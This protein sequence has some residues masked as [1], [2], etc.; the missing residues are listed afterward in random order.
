MATRQYSLDHAKG[1]ISIFTFCCWTFFFFILLL[2]RLIFRVV[3]LSCYLTL[4]LHQIH[5]LCHSAGHQIDMVCFNSVIYRVVVDIILFTVVVSL[6][7]YFFR[8]ISMRVVVWLDNESR[9]RSMQ[10]HFRYCC[11]SNC[12]SEYFF[13]D[14]THNTSKGKVI[15]IAAFVA[16][17]LSFIHSIFFF[18]VNWKIWKKTLHK[19]LIFNIIIFIHA[20]RI[21]HLWTNKNV[22]P[23]KCTME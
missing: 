10:S 3:F 1:S 7:I 6:F 2:F 5:T 23:K 20:N 9:F 15:W 22:Y 19:L 21:L 13:F 11:F 17:L 12:F 4:K 18:S 16:F 14:W 8:S